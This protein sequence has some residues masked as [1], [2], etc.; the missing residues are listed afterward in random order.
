MFGFNKKEEFQKTF[1]DTGPA[2]I[3]KDQSFSFS[4]FSLK[5]ERGIFKVKIHGET[6]FEQALYLF[7]DMLYN[8]KIK[9][10]IYR[11]VTSRNSPSNI[12]II[13]PKGSSKTAILEAIAAACHDVIYINSKTTIAGL[14]QTIQENPNVRIILIDEIDKILNRGERDAIRGFLST[15]KLSRS[16]VKHGNVEIEIKNMITICTANS[17]E[18]L[19]GPFLDRFTRFYLTEYTEEQFKE[20]C[21]FRM[22]EYPKELI[23][24]IAQFFIDQKMKDVRNIVKLRSMIRPT[25]SLETIEMIVSS[26][27][28]LENTSTKNVNWNKK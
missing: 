6:E 22:P 18:N 4:K 27:V 1:K 8:D 21:A 7:R 2:I 9:F 28:E 16:T 20:I 3:P 12:I 14:V 25:D 13:G 15:G 11:M 23:Y 24:N 19:D 17:N 5:K 26:V 10:L